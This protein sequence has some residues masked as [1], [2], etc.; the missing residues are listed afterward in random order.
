VLLALGDRRPQIDPEAWVAPTA[1]VAGDVT[2]GARSSIWY[3]A[4]LRADTDP[5][6]IGA[7]SNVQD[8]SVLHADPGFPLRL[9]DGV[10]VGHLVMLHGCTIDDDVLV[11][12][13][14]VVLN[15]ARIGAGSLIAAG[16]LVTQ[17]TEI[18]PRS[19]VMGSPA[20]VRRE[21]TDDDVAG[22]RLNAEHYRELVAMHRT[23]TPL[24]T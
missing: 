7:G 4:T 11:G 14:A 19:M 21:L 3:G 24:G 1:T 22:I 18:P 17:G 13:G 15:G 2:V 5:I 9:G 23:A 10:T 8:G 12:I 20:K 6:V 16:A